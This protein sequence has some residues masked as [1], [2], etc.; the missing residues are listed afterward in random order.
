MQWRR[1]SSALLLTMAMTVGPATA[2]EVGAPA[3]DFK[4]PSTTGADIALSD[5]KGKQWVFL[6]FYGADAVNLK[7]AA[8]LG[9]T[10]PQSVLLR[11]DRVVQ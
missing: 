3:P 7:V 4:L 6:E 1:I 2:V 5:F 8:A 11:A 10:I 9:L